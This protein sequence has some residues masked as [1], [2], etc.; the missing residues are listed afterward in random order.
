[1]RF[2][3]SLAKHRLW[4]F[5]PES[6]NTTIKPN[7]KA[8]WLCIGAHFKICFT[9][10]PQNTL[11]LPLWEQLI[12]MELNIIVRR[13]RFGTCVRGVISIPPK[14][15]NPAVLFKISIR[16][17][18]SFLSPRWMWAAAEAAKSKV[19]ERKKYNL[20]WALSP[21]IE[22]KISTSVKYG[23]ILYQDNW[24]VHLVIYM[25]VFISAWRRL[26]VIMDLQLLLAAD[27]F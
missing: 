27:I 17:S 5:L 11:R 24:T 18:D 25:T 20:P 14:E 15:A 12:N 26:F 23:V 7:Q 21:I 4:G 8:W 13:D 9:N 1:M 3:D 10:I 16:A 22:R 6:G 2:L 19:D